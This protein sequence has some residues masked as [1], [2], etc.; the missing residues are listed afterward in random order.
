MGKTENQLLTLNL[1]QTQAA[2]TDKYQA[3]EKL[4]C[5]ALLM[6]SESGEVQGKIDKQIRKNHNTDFTDE[7]KHDIALEIGDVLWT[8]ARLADDL[9]YTLA[10]IANMNLEKLASRDQRDKIC[11]SGDHR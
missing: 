3:D 4:I 2:V 11:G 5:H 9:G 6:G 7:Q 8:C 10:D 1:Y